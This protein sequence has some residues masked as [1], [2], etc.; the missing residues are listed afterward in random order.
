MQESINSLL[1][2]HG[3]RK[4]MLEYPVTEE[5]RN[6][7]AKKIGGQWESLATF[8]GVCH[9]EVEDIKETKDEPLDRRL[10]MMRRWKEL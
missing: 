2:T 5:H 10:A 3:V 1:E 4:K 6:M 7:I 9:E 8:I